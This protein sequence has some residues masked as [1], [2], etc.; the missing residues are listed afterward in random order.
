MEDLLSGTNKDDKFPEGWDNVSFDLY[1]RDEE[2]ELCLQ[3]DGTTA[4]CRWVATPRMYHIVPP[5][6]TA[7]K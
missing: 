4:D 1:P 6:S 3:A 5:S 2:D 7:A